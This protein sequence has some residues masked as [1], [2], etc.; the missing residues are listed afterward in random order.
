[1]KQKNIVSLHSV[2]KLV[3]NFYQT[4]LWLLLVKAL[5]FTYLCTYI[6]IEFKAILLVLLT[7]AH[8]YVWLFICITDFNELKAHYHTILRLMPDDYE[9]TVGKLQNYITFDRIC[10][11]LSSNNFT[12][13]N[14]MILDCLI[15]RMRHRIDMLDLCDALEHITSLEELKTIT[16][17]I[18]SGECS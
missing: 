3:A 13:A 6:C 7:Y 4:R 15:E 12:I 18:R 2:L 17:K 9:V 14:K 16:N 10:T 8:N 5:M 11:I 1:M